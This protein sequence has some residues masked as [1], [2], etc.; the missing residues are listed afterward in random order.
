MSTSTVPVRPA[1][2]YRPRAGSL[3]PYFASDHAR[4]GQ[5]VLGLLWLLDGG[6]QFQSFMYSNG[7]IKMIT[8][9]AQ[10][11]PQWV[12]SPMIWAAHLARHDLAVFNTGFA[13][14]QCAVGL[15]I[16]YRPTVKP[17]LLASFGWAFVVWWFGEG[18]GMMFMGGMAT[19][20]TGAPG[21]VLIYVLIGAIVWPRGR[22][23]GLL[24]VRGARIAWAALWIVMAWLWLQPQS[25][26]PDVF[27]STLAA[28]PA[29]M[30]WLASLQS[31][32]GGWVEGNGVW[33]ALLLASF[34]AA[35]AVGVMVR[36]RAKELL[37]ASA[38]LNLILWV[39]FQGL[40]GIF[41]GGATDPN[42][43]LLFIVLAY[44]LYSLA[45][46]AGDE[47]FAVAS[48]ELR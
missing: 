16:L 20:L 15:G 24:G 6:L 12:H 22:P 40:G 46:Y 23:G 30:G 1:T 8:T 32:V 26:Q 35:A 4:T 17:A 10:G 21:A 7:F 9:T 3:R 19:P 37:I 47:P 18:F 33:L 31:T 29:G 27:A 41:A 48:D 45:P 5:T 44:V 13:L 28:A 14:A 36:W 38:V 42:A 2:G 11:Q 25:A 39:L 34:S 43:G